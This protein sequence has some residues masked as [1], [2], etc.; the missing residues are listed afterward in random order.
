VRR[1]VW[2]A[3]AAGPVVHGAAAQGGAEV[4]DF[5]GDWSA[6]RQCRPFCSS[7]APPIV[8]D[9]SSQR[10]TAANQEDCKGCKAAVMIQ[11]HRCYCAHATLLV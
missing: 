9:S 6:F 1:P 4:V 10:K 2:I 3:A 11:R 7:V 5:K 8:A